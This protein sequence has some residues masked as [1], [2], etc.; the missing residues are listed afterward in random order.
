[1]QFLHRDHE[2]SI[3]LIDLQRAKYVAGP[4]TNFGAYYRR[5]GTDSRP[6]LTDCQVYTRSEDLIP[7][8][9]I[10][11]LS[12]LVNPDTNI[13]DADRSRELRQLVLNFGL[14]WLEGLVSFD[15]ARDFLV[16]KRVRES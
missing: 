13:P 2:D 14:P 3:L 8:S 10:F 16:R 4:Y 9:E 6:K 7:T 15:G 1:V 5:Y 11:R 12:D